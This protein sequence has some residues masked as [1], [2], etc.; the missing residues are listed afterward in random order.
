MFR[1]KNKTLDHVD[2]DKLAKNS[3]TYVI[4][5]LALGA[6]TF[7]GVCGDPR[8]R[9]SAG[10]R[11]SAAKVGDEVISRAEFDRAYRNAYSQYQRQF[12]DQFNPGAM[13]LAHNV[14]QQ[15]VDDRIVYTTAVAHGMKASDEEVTKVLAE[16]EIF[17]DEK[18]V[19][20][21]ENFN[22]FLRSNGY[23]EASFQEEVRRNLTVQKLRRFVTDTPFVST[24]AAE[25][26][27]RLAETKLNLEY[28]KFDPQKVTVDVSGA[29]ID[30]FLADEAGKKRVKEYYETNKREFDQPEQVQARHI[31]VAFKG[32]RNATP[33]AAKRSKE[34]AKKR[35]EELLAKAKGGADFAALAKAE[36]DE[37][38]GK[39]SGGDLGFFT[40]E[41]MVKEFSDAAFALGKGQISGVVE[42]PFGFHIIKVEDKKAAKNVPLDVAQRDIAKT[43]LGKDKKPALAQ[44][45]AEAAL[46]ALKAGKDVA[47]LLAKYD[48]KWAETGDFAA[49]ARYVPGIGTS[50]EISE[51]L[52]AL[53]KPG[54]L[55]D[56]VA[57]VRGNYF[58]ARLKS[59]QD[60]DMSKFDAA[61][62]KELAESAAY[63]EGYSSFNALEKKLKDDMQKD[64]KIWM[65]PEYMALD[66][67]Q[68]DQKNP[69]G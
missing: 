66:D 26:D 18:G 61:K 35:A 58:I 43:I 25:I 38:A 6:M 69:E 16:A 13:R 39:T 15:L 33:E 2:A 62:G 48:V 52:L 21:E 59:R 1:M 3:G 60:A 67:R 22:N 11:G 55:V 44:A 42:S 49:N 46:K 68:V 27:Y 37:A 40:R 56:Q 7:F 34:A 8:S 17:K 4:L 57:D 53:K 45:D 24:K 29:D 20:S 54:E 10:P 28:L 50:Q 64:A 14:M 23:T 63:T 65:N 31:L 12:S 19:F 41:G 51:S 36:T 47:G 30:K 5:L 32:S 9:N